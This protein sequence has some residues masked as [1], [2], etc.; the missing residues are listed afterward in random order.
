M[1]KTA[2]R[3]KTNP[4]YNNT[5][6]EN[7]VKKKDVWPENIFD[8]FRTKEKGTIS[9]ETGIVPYSINQEYINPAGVG[10]RSGAD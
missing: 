7:N 8:S 5:F 4:Y 10:A 9:A 3:F 2:I 1:A 6:F